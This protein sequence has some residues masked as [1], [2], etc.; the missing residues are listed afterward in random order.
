M[1]KYQQSELMNRPEEMKLK[2][3]MEFSRVYGTPV[4]G[5]NELHAEMIGIITGDQK[6]FDSVMEKWAKLLVIAGLKKS[7][8][9]SMTFDDFSDLCKRFNKP[10]KRKLKLKF[11]FELNGKLYS[12]PKKPLQKD[13]EKIEEAVRANRPNIESYIVAV[14]FKDVRLSSSEHWI[15]A[16]LVHKEKLFLEHMDGGTAAAHIAAIVEVLNKKA[17]A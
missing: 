10:Q 17:K 5:E 13:M 1:I 2:K 7:D 15:E 4:K 11:D 8:A 9:D 16:H 12:A 3:F 14:L 6:K